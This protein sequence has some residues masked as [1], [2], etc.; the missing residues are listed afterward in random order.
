[1]MAET[2]GTSA[3]FGPLVLLVQPASSPERNIGP[4]LEFMSSQS[5]VRRLLKLLGALS[6]RILST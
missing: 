1:M 5:A 2:F 3:P 4:R 6:R